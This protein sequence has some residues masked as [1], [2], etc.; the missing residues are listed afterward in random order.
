M[1]QF[2]KHMNVKIVSMARG[3]TNGFSPNETRPAPL[4]DTPSGPVMEAFS[5]DVDR[6]IL[7][8][9][10][11][12]EMSN[13][14]DE[15]DWTSVSLRTHVN[16]LEGFGVTLWNTQGEPGWGD[17]ASTDDGLTLT[18]DIHPIDLDDLKAAYVGHNSSF[19]WLTLRAGAFVALDGGEGNEPVYGTQ[20]VGH[21]GASVSELVEDATRL[22]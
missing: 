12:E 3:L 2:N 7:A 22:V 4:P 9:T 11:S 20:V 14:S 15:V 17:T 21:N 18:V 8:L 1:W 13:A 5:L 16:G 6:G 10:F 19:T